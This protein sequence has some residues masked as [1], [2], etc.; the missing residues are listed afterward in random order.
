MTLKHNSKALIFAILAV[1]FVASASAYTS[2]FTT[3]PPNTQPV[4]ESFTIAGKVGQ[5]GSWES[6][7]ESIMIE[8]SPEGSSTWFVQKE[9]DYGCFGSSCTISSDSISHDTAEDVEYRIVAMNNVGN[10]VPYSPGP[11]T[12]T[13]QQQGPAVELASVTASDYS[14][15]KSDG[16]TTL[17]AGIT[18]NRDTELFV[19]MIWKAD[20]T[21]IASG[22]YYINA[23]STETVTKQV[24][25]ST[26][27]SNLQTDTAYD[28]KGKVSYSDVTDTKTAPQTLKVESHQKAP[29]SV[30]I[31]NIRSTDTHI[32]K[33]ETTHFKADLRPNTD[34]G[35]LEV[36]F[37]SDGTLL[38]SKSL[39][40]LSGSSSTTAS[41]SMSWSDLKDKLGT[42]KHHKLTVKVHNYQ[43]TNSETESDAFFL[44]SHQK[45]FNIVDYGPEGT[46][47]NPV[48][49]HL[50]LDDNPS[51][52]WCKWKEGSSVSRDSGTL[53]AK[54]DSSEPKWKYSKH[55]SEGSHKVTFQCF[56]G[57]RTL[58]SEKTTTFTVEKQNQQKVAITALRSTLDTINQGETTHFK[59]DIKAYR[60]IS[61]LEVDFYVD[62]KKV[63]DNQVWNLGSGDTKTVSSSVTWNDLRNKVETGQHHDL[64]VKLHNYQ[65]DKSKTE[66]NAFYLSEKEGT[67]CRKFS[68]SNLDPELQ[69][70]ESIAEEGN[71]YDSGIKLN[72]NGGS[73]VSG[74]L[75]IY[76][77][78]S[79]QLMDCNYYKN[80]YNDMASFAGGNVNA[81][82]GSS[83]SFSFSYSGK[84][85]D[86]LEYGET[87][88]L[89]AVFHSDSTVYVGNVGSIQWRKSRNGDNS[90]TASFTWDKHPAK[91]GQT[92]TFDGSGSSDPDGDIEQY[93]WSFG[94]GTGYKHGSEE[95]HT[96]GSPGTYDVTLRVK[97]SKGNKDTVTKSV[98]VVQQGNNGGSQKPSASFTWSPGQPY[99]GDTV[100][101]DA[102]GS[103]DPNSDIV[104]YTWYF[105]DGNTG[106][107]RTVDHSFSNTGDYDVQLVTED[108][109]GNTDT[110]VRTVPVVRN[111]AA[112][113]YQLSG[114]RFDKEIIRR[115][116]ST[117]ASVTLSNLGKK[118]VFNVKFTHSAD[119]VR[120]TEI[121]VDAHSQ[122]TLSA[123]VSPHK[124]SMIGVKV[125]T[126]DAPCGHTHKKKYR[127]L[128][129]IPAKEQRP[130]LNVNVQNQNGRKLQNA[131]VQ[132]EG[133][134]ALTRY[135]G[136]S[137]HIFLKLD[138]GDYDLTVSKTGYET[139]H[140][141]INLQEG[142]TSSI[143]VTLHELGNQ[144]TLTALVQDGDGN[145]LADA[146]VTVTDGTTKTSTTD[147][148][149]R[150]TLSL[151]AG[152]HTVKAHKDGYGTR[153]KTVNI[154]EGE[155]TTEIFKLYKS[156]NKGLHITNVQ[157]P[158]SVCRGSTMKAQVTIRNDGG[159]HEVV[160]LAGSGLGGI[161]AMPSFSIQPGNTVTK[162]LYFTNVQGSGSEEFKVTVNNHGN[163]REYRTV[164]V[165]NCGTTGR[166]QASGISMSLGYT[167]KP[168][169]AVEGDIIKVKG[170]VDGVPGR[171]NVD[172]KVD[173]EVKASVRTQPDGYYQT[174]I[175]AE[176]PGPHT[177]TATT[178]QVSDT[179]PLRIIPTA[180]VTSLQAPVSKFEGQDYRICAQVE[181]QV[182]P[183]VVLVR[184]GEVVQSKKQNGKV[185]FNQTARQPGTHKYKVAALTSGSDNE[186]STT[187]EVLKMGVET[188]S[189]PDQIA[190]VESGSGLVKVELYNTN[191]KEKRYSLQLKGLPDTWVSQSEKQ[192]VLQ[193]GEKKTVY[194][195]LT[196]QEEGSYKPSISV[197]SGGEEVY[198]QKL[199]VITGGTTD[200]NPGRK[201]GGFLGQV[202]HGITSFFSH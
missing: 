60:D 176:K 132:V 46:V 134:T 80:H 182:K 186:A 34:I 188:S 172:I 171:A 66:N 97:D 106:H 28:L 202:W 85:V 76:V 1:L 98:T 92:V 104:D 150:A 115:G 105:G 24:T 61:Y 138:Q 75:G 109:Q 4:G 119:T 5:S 37:K 12:V 151:S 3:S 82:A 30:H 21:E 35:Y 157:F 38:K 120:E 47:H 41:V 44:A 13:F 162:T 154:N 26:L 201:D 19:H 68:D 62:G 167:K 107:G 42:G 48:K 84:P 183:Q 73:D 87:Y 69:N 140:R 191:D 166:N 129:V 197:T 131:R 156:G 51:T 152:E 8:S 70:F 6:D 116:T 161:T 89:V 187:V 193:K 143:T 173:D 56:N 43:L 17:K 142:D 181:S 20:S 25:Y 65:I 170:F 74:N 36:D 111:P 163:D 15:S 177:V 113:S 108:S 64:K 118:Q 200:S 77:K 16:S 159:F 184:D 146:D 102:S 139:R 23:G 135:T 14:V 33:G 67:S 99:P 29:P 100:T 79:N 192:V 148:N 53:M 72:N 9:K 141:S 144:G 126:E 153:V 121:T 83:G 11:K 2:Q 133:P 96:F 136:T 57:Q 194:F 125:S 71:S 7:L 198:W 95:T 101:F 94:D 127:E 180:T 54:P 112:C 52:G 18:N 164:N 110:A 189:F 130:T 39:Y 175:T 174:W 128:V 86:D 185:C 31:T 169:M 137:G 199:D 149:G 10:T 78:S 145:R 93:R 81:N 168:H 63:R 158:S 165:N 49:L 103:S 178:G 195:Y 123:S 155:G 58:T 22:W 32:N 196:P 147:N 55:F 124:D 160:S 122:R 27:E 190:S 179:K 91:V 90:P 88:V 50:K 114:I 117:S 40:D 45:D 59:A